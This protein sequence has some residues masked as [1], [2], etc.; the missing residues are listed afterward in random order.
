MLHHYCNSLYSIY[1]RLALHHAELDQHRNETTAKQLA[2]M[3]ETFEKQNEVAAVKRLKEEIKTAAA[4]DAAR[5][6]KLR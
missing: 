3:E 6:I 1:V 2:G 5:K 4:A